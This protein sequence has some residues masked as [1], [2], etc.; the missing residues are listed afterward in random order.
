MVRILN[1]FRKQRQKWWYLEMYIG[2]KRGKRIL[3]NDHKA[4]S[5]LRNRGFIGINRGEKLS[6]DLISAYFLFSKKKIEIYEGK[7]KLSEKD[8]LDIIGGNIFF[9]HAYKFLRERGYKPFFK[10]NS[11]YVEGKKV[12]VI[13]YPEFIVFSNIKNS[14]TNVIVVDEDGDCILYA[15][16][17]F[18]FDEKKLNFS[19]NKDD[20]LRK[21][22]K[23][24]LSIKA[25]SKYGSDFRI[26]DGKQTHAK[27]LLNIEDKLST[28]DLVARVR[29]AHSVKKIYVQGYIKSRLKFFTVKWITV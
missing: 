16:E 12:V 21:I 27:Y 19:K 4:S 2:Q 26:Y 24:K 1:N 6:I 9:Y 25:G 13:K 20:F 18:N 15:I 22:E 23:S 5:T 11:L 28:K 10:N 17:K 29:V 14:F 8:I 3:F 7:K